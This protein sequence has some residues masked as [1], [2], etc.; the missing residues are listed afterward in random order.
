LATQQYRFHTQPSN[1]RATEALEPFLVR[2]GVP[3]S[4]ADAI[5]AYRRHG[6]NDKEILRRFA[7]S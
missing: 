3:D 1:W 5:I 7:G 6:A 4:Q 2:H